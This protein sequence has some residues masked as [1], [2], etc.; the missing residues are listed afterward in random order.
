MEGGLSF[1]RRAEII[2]ANWAA[3][4]ICNSHHFHFDKHC[5]TIFLHIINGTSF[6]YVFF[7]RSQFA[8]SWLSWLDRTEE[9]WLYHTLCKWEYF[10]YKHCPP[11]KVLEW[12][13]SKPAPE[14]SRRSSQHQLHLHTLVLPWNISHLQNAGVMVHSASWKFLILVIQMHLLCVILYAASYFSLFFSSPAV[15]KDAIWTEIPFNSDTYSEC[16][17]KQ[18]VKRT[19][20]KKFVGVQLCNSLRYKIYLSDSLTGKK[21]SNQCCPYYAFLK[22]IIVS[23]IRGVLR[24]VLVKHDQ[25]YLI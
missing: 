1:R 25:I 11:N 24:W 23:E 16:K 8:A 3:F 5:G 15:G 22:D 9:W 21:H 18:Y 17:G 10:Q 14:D 6:L 4:C 7:I 2:R 12:T 20:Y 13:Y 19:W